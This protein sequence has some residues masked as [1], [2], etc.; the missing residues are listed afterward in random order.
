[1]SQ[2]TPDNIKY[3]DKYACITTNGAELRKLSVQVNTDFPTQVEDCR[4][5]AKKMEDLL[6]IDP[7]KGYVR[8]NII[9][10]GLAARQLVELEGKD[11]PRLSVIIFPEGQRK[12]SKAAIFRMVN[13]QIIDQVKPWTYK[14]EG[15]LS[16]PN[17]FH[18]T[19]RFYGVKVGFI[20]LDTLMPRE[21]QFYGYEAVVMQHEIDHHDGRLFVDKAHIPVVAGKKLGP[22][23]PCDCGSG[24][25]YKKCCM[26]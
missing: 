13:P 6:V 17:L 24:K 3:A 10:Y 22:N 15:C 16:F 12:D 19:S 21:I 26:D 4:I 1:M 14:G 5:F 8:G 25:K 9:G 7:A 11:A 18:N 23:E 20:D 2:E